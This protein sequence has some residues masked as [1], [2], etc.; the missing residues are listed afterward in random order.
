MIIGATGSGK[1]KSLIIPILDKFIQDGLSGLIIDIKNDF[2]NDIY[3]IAKKHG[4]EED[5]IEIGSYETAKKINLLN[6]LKKDEVKELF[7]YLFKFDNRSEKN[8]EYWEGMSF[9][10]LEDIIDVIYYINKYEVLPFTFY[11]LYLILSNKNYADKIYE[12]FLSLP[13]SVEKEQIVSNIETY[14]FHVFKQK[15]DSAF[16]EDIDENNRSWTYQRYTNLVKDFLKDN[17]LENINN[18]SENKDFV[19]DF[20][21]LLYEENKIIVIRFD[22]IFSYIGNKISKFIRKKMISDIIKYNNNIPEEDRKET[23]IIADEFQNIISLE[24][25]LFND[26]E[27]FDKS[28]SFKC[29]QIIATQSLSSLYS[30]TNNSYQVD[31]LINNCRNKFFLSNEDIKTNQYFHE[32]SMGNYSKELYELKL[33]ECYYYYFN[34]IK[35]EKELNLIKLTLNKYNNLIKK[36]NKK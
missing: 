24:E 31:T 21:K 27:W 7:R 1:T 19:L 14:A 29:Y 22:L 15:N 3:K 12:K 5:I 13:D 6:G 26:N 25:G 28:R 8:G 35:G 23:F 20:Q 16:K 34:N 11:L 2:T 18:I 36:F 9:R 33:G 4:R 32:L 10:V 17:L 30:K